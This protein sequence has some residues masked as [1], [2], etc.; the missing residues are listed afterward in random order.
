[1]GHVIERIAC[2]RGHEVVLTIDAGEEDRFDS[3]AFRS[4]DVAIEFTRPDAAYANC[5][6][7]MDKSVPVVCGTTGWT[8]HLPELEE[9]CRREGKTLFWASNFSI[10][11]NLFFSFSRMFARLMSRHDQAA[12]ISVR[13]V[14]SP[15][16]SAPEI[17]ICIISI[18]F[19][20][21]N[22]L[23]FLSGKFSAFR[24]ARLYRDSR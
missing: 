13:A 12:R 3:I 15:G 11:V 5:S 19:I 9:R 24:Q 6:R 17:F 20:L 1:M 23:Y 14:V 2:S 16:L 8:E 18:F 22:F 4:A 10:G 21:F 7:C